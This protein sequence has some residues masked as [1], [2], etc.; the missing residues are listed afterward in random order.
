MV[1]LAACGS[2]GSDQGTLAQIRKDGVLRHHALRRDGSIRDTVMYSMSAGEWPEAR[3][4]LQ[5][6]LAKQRD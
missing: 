4:E 6:R 5:A 3:A 1:S 2:G